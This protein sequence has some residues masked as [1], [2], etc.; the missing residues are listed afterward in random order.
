MNPFLMIRVKEIE[1]EDPGD[2]FR[3]FLILLLGARNKLRIS[4]RIR[5][6]FAD[7]SQLIKRS[8]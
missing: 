1:F 2:F 4:D 7:F 3:I 5:L 6:E 8:E